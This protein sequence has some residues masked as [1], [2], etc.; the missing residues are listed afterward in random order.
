M[1]QS[2]QPNGLPQMTNDPIRIIT[3]FG[4]QWTTVRS[5][6]EKHWGI[7]TNSPELE[8]IVGTSLKQVARQAK[9]LGDMLI[10]SEFTKEQDLTWLADHPWT[11]GMFP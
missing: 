11:T 4:S 3:A 7:L 9:N 10:Q 2:K 1:E 8:R 6:L 5:I